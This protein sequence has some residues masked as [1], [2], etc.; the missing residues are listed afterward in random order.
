MTPHLKFV[1]PTVFLFLNYTTLN[2]GK[3][4]E[5]IYFFLPIYLYLILLVIAY[6]TT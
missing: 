1:K 5:N 2:C 4:E 3:K 6:F